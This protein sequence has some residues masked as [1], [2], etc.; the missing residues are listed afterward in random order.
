MKSSFRQNPC[1]TFF[2]LVLPKSEPNSKSS[3]SMHIFS[4]AL[5]Q[6]L[7]LRLR[8]SPL[9]NRNIN[10]QPAVSCSSSNSSP[11]LHCSMR[12]CFVHNNNILLDTHDH[13]SN[14]QDATPILLLQSYLK[15]RCPHVGKV[16]RGRPALGHR[17][18]ADRSLTF[19]V[20]TF[21]FTL[22]HHPAQF[23]KLFRPMTRILLLCC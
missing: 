21:S 6:W 11:V 20:C 1:T 8:P 15:R 16:M 14:T 10:S 3:I 2:L 19:N 12:A 23:R 18:L 4:S 5:V 22:D 17:S 9:I 13:Y 7:F